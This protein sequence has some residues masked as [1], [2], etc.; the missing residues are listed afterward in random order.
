MRA[1]GLLSTSDQLVAETA[2]DTTHKNYKRR[3]PMPE[4][5]EPAFPG[6]KR[7]QDYA[8]DCT[9]TFFIQ[10]DIFVYT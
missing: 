9:A 5:F 3:K 6:I 4:I 1:L 8:L 2:T 7:P 10:F